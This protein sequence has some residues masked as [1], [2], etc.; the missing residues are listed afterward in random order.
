MKGNGKIG[1]VH[2]FLWK[3]DIIYV[4]CHRNGIKSS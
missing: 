1:L 3:G 4:S 2:E